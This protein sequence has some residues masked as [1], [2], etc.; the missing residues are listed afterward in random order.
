MTREAD[1]I[2]GAAATATGSAGFLY[3]Y[4]LATEVANDVILWGNVLLVVGGLFLMVRR[5][6]KR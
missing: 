2:I 4:N 1:S 5:F 3:W 6:K